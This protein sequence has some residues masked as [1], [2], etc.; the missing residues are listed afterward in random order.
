MKISNI[1]R[2]LRIMLIFSGKHQ[3]KASEIAC[4]IEISVRQVYRDIECLKLAGVPVYADK[5]GFAILPDFFMP[6]ISLEMPE[7]LTLSLFCNSIKS[8]KGTPY[9]EIMASACDKILNALPESVK[10]VFLD[11]GPDMMVDFGLETKV[12]YEKID[13]IFSLVYEASMA[14]KQVRLKYYSIERKKITERIVDPYA[15]KLCF[16][17]WYLIGYCHLRRQIRTFRVDRIRYAEVLPSSFTVREGF[18]VEEF[19][20]SSWAI[21]KGQR[22]KVKLKF[23]PGIADFVSEC[24][25]HPSQKLKKNSN[26]T[27]TA[28]FE[29]EGL[30]EIKIWI[31]GFGQSVEVLEPKELR[32]DIKNTAIKIYKNYS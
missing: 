24:I 22:F 28:E 10:K 6:K 14:K 2:L 4:D 5:N 30:S 12:D 17:I 19:F 25:W 11:S 13:R 29:V 20:T 26:G 18:D 31:L 32:D 27:L 16:G 9:S 8:Q 3:V 7:I 21:A 1:W 15:F 23:A